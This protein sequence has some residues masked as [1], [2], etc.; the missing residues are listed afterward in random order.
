LGNDFHFSDRLSVAGGMWTMTQ[1]T[2]HRSASHSRYVGRRLSQTDAFFSK[3]LL[4]LQLS[5]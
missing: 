3:L 2:T 5:C 4:Q 1:Q